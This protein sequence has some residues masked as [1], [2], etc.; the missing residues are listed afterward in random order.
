L[1]QLWK[2]VI[3]KRF[4]LFAC[5]VAFAS[6]CL[7]SASAQ[8]TVSSIAQMNLTAAN[9]PVCIGD[10]TQYTVTIAGPDYLARVL[11]YYQWN[12][13]NPAKAEV[14]WMNA[15]GTPVRG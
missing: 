4:V 9:Q 8:N 12:G 13:C 15:N 7:R 1:P 14:Q 3:V 6:P 11:W 2:E 10:N 5:I